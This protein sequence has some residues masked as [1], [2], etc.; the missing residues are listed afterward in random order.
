MITLAAAATS[1]R[2][3][4]Y[5]EAATILTSNS[6]SR[7]SDVRRRGVRGHGGREGEVAGQQSARAP[8][9]AAGRVRV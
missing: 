8:Q 1:R 5:F 4:W 3:W 2:F 7:L 6:C 9:P